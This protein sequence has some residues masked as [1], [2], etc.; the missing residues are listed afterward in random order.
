MNSQFGRK[1]GSWHYS[2][3][4]S[5]QFWLRV[6]ALKGK[7]GKY[8]YLLGCCLQDLESRALHALEDAERKKRNA[9]K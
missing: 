7:D 1:D 4:G 6:N 8:L 5:R 9:T 3:D 2:G